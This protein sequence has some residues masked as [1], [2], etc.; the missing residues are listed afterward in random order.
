MTTLPKEGSG[1]LG[2]EYVHEAS[3]CK[4]KNGHCDNHYC[5]FGG[6]A[7]QADAVQGPVWLLAAAVEVG[8][9]RSV[10]SRPLSHV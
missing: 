7:L 3:G 5:Q 2:R 4:I 8:H 9:G 10:R 1:R 6:T